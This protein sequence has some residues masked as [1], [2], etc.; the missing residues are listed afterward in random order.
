[1]RIVVMS[2]SHRNKRNLFNIV[3]MHLNDADLFIFLGDG[4]SDIEDVIALYPN[5]PIHIVAG[6]CDWYSTKPLYKEIIFDKKHIFFSHGHPFS[7]KHSYNM[8]IE[9]AEKREA[10]IVLFG[11]THVQYKEYRENLAVMNPGSVANSE[12][13]MIDIIGDDIMLID[14]KI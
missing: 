4:E 5:L 12:Y 2:D 11:H 8:I 7:V 10:D 14:A 6:N 3:E 13:G 9:E 1:M